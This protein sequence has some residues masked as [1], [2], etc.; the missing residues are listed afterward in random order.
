MKIKKYQVGGFNGDPL[1]ALVAARESTNTNAP[2]LGAILARQIEDGPDLM[3]ADNINR[4]ERQ[5]L[6]EQPGGMYYAD[7]AGLEQVNPVFELLSFA[8]PKVFQSIGKKG[9]KM[10]SDYISG[11]S[12]KELASKK[13]KDIVMEAID[14]MKELAERRAT[15]N[16]QYV[17]DRT[18]RKAGAD[19]TQAFLNLQ[20][21]AQEVADEAMGAEMFN[22]A[23][24]EN[25]I[26]DIFG[27]ARVDD[28][29]D[30]GSMRFRKI[31]D[32]GNVDDVKRAQSL[33]G[34]EKA[35]EY[36][37]LFEDLGMDKKDVMRMLEERFMM[38]KDAVKLPLNLYGKQ[39]KNLNE[40][41]GFITPM[42][43]VSSG[44]SC[45]RCKKK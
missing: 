29:I 26:D 32:V 5:L 9:V 44:C 28:I 8:G 18:L 38:D 16:L 27:Q 22:V 35:D 10:I 7:P 12:S 15:E 23:K 34:Y 33:G 3:G 25:Q 37:M 21:R 2:N 1:K 19:D 45:M 17:A 13:A 36:A 31:K 11:L 6:M 24:F 4:L 14:P 42:K 30:N 43:P 20:G 41:G 40:Q 39:T